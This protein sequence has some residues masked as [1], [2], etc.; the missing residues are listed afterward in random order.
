[1]KFTPG[2]SNQQ[3]WGGSTDQ[4]ND[5]QLDGVTVN[6]PGYGGSYL[7]PNVDWIEE[8]QVKGLGA[9]AEYGNFQGGVVN[10][11]TKSGGNET[12]GGVRFYYEDASLR[13][14]TSTPSRP[15]PSRTPPMRSTPTS[16]VL[17]SATGSTT[18][19]RCSRSAR[20]TNIVDGINSSP[21]TR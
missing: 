20:T 16:A 15:G 3:L 9:G 10:I 5:Y 21:Q 4:A 1:M 18:S 7:L 2:G 14:P 12:H 19:S 11:V 6:S 8:L 13:T 17:S